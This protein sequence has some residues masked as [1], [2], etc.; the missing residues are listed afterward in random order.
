V[1]ALHEYPAW[2][3]AQIDDLMLAVE[4]ADADEFASENE[5]RATF[6]RYLA[7]ASASDSPSRPADVPQAKAAPGLPRQR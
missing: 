5:M 4:E 7:R 2:R 3:A 6:G 1:K